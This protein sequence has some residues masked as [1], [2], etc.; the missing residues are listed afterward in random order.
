MKNDAVVTTC[1]R[2]GR[3]GK[4]TAIQSSAVTAIETM[5]PLAEAMADA[6]V[7]LRPL[8]SAVVPDE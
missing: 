7:C 2:C 4:G 8:G 5:T 3:T 6:S 1:R